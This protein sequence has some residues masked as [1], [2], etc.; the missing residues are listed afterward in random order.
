MDRRSRVARIGCYPGSLLGS[1][2]S[3]GVVARLIALVGR[4]TPFRSLPGVALAVP[5][6]SKHLSPRAPAGM[7][8]SSFLG[9]C[10]GLG[11]NAG[12]GPGHARMRATRRGD[13]GTKGDY[14]DELV[15]YTVQK[16]R[17]AARRYFVHNNHLYTPMAVTNSTGAV[18]E[19]YSYTAYGERSIV[20]SSSKVSQ[21]GNGRGFTGYQL[22]EE[23]GLYYARARMYSSGQGRFVS[24]DPAEYIDG[25]SLYSAFF[26]PNQTDSEGTTAGSGSG[27]FCK[28]PVDCKTP[29]DNSIKKCTADA[30]AEFDKIQKV[31]DDATGAAKRVKETAVE[32]A[33]RIA[34]A[35]H[36]RAIGGC[37]K[38]LSQDPAR[39]D[40]GGYALCVENANVARDQAVGA[41]ESAADSAYSAAEKAA[42][43][44]RFAARQ[45]ALVVFRT[46]TES[47]RSVYDACM[48]QNK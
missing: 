44:A 8:G 32:L 41:A 24:R 16:P 10:L 13:A 39:N 21:V 38:F 9:S 22:D 25:Y 12:M 37:R 28:K 6:F 2:R 36:E 14:V 47:A 46:C 1:A 30:K 20:G 40:P 26:V 48:E 45:A 23:S 35:A 19:R 5:Q 34:N 33:R 3:Y 18:V 17:H 15:S 43:V 11:P 4:L 42:G 27:D 29:Y 7:R 31:Y